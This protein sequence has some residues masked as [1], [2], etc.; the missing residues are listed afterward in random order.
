MS[1]A[2]INRQQDLIVDDRSNDLYRVNKM[3][4]KRSP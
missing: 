3:H 4:S 1:S 2:Y